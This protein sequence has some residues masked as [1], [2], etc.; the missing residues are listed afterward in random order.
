MYWWNIFILI[1]SLLYLFMSSILFKLLVVDG[2]QPPASYFS[3][4]LVLHTNLTC[5]FLKDDRNIN[6]FADS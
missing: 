2:V 4:V 6:N 3:L 1:L 5:Y